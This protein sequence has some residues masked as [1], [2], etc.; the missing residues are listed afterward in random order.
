MALEH[1]LFAQLG[2]PSQ[3]PRD[4]IEYRIEKRNHRI[5]ALK[6]RGD[7]DAP[8]RL[9]YAHHLGH[10]AVRIGNHG[11]FVERG[12]VIEAVVGIVEIQRVAEAELDM[13]PTVFGD[14]FLRPR[15]HL[16]RRI[17]RDHVRVGRISVE[18][19]SGAD[20]DFQY[21]VAGPEIQAL[22]NLMLAIDKDP[23]EEKIVEARQIG[24][25]AAFVRLGHRGS[26]LGSEGP[27]DQSRDGTISA[28]P[29][30]SRVD[31][32]QLTLDGIYITF[33][34]SP[35]TAFLE[36]RNNIAPRE[37][38]D[39]VRAQVEH[40]RDFAGV[41]QYVVFIGHV[42]PTRRLSGI[43]SGRDFVVCAYRTSQG[44]DISHL[45]VCRQQRLQF[46]TISFIDSD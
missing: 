19:D 10:H 2:G 21:A 31:S 28:P 34:K 13:P 16:R 27:G 46:G 4:R 36:G 7:R 1:V 11:Q 32:S 35:L 23:A 30:G 12:D 3:L 14:A 15:E 26:S 39:R 25:D 44:A 45:K 5:R 8:A 17:A 20:A 6:V 41:Q 22:D 43:L 33:A 42:S 38:I 9:T 18:R 37:F 40:E 29:S 24:V